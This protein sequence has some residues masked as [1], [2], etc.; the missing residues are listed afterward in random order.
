[1]KVRKGSA[2][3]FLLPILLLGI[4]APIPTYASVERNTP[5]CAKIQYWNSWNRGGASIY[6]DDTVV[7]VWN[8]EDYQAELPVYNGTIYMPMRTAEL[9]LGASVEWDEENARLAI[10]LRKTLPL[11]IPVGTAPFEKRWT[12][13]LLAQRDLEREQGVE[14][15]LRPD[16]TVEV[17]GREW[18]M[19]NAA[20][21]T[22]YPLTL[23]G[24]LYLPI[25]NVAQLCGKTILWLPDPIWGTEHLYLYDPPTQGQLDYAAEYSLK[26]QQYADQ[27]KKGFEDIEARED[28]TEETFFEAVRALKAITD[29]AVSLPYPSADTPRYEAVSVKMRWQETIENIDFCLR[30]PGEYPKL[31]PE[32][33]QNKRKSV[34][35]SG[36]FRYAQLQESIDHMKLVID[37]VIANQA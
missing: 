35:S 17:D 1:M 31:K 9:W 12:E 5:F 2:I 30:A 10:G 27:L 29:E 11:Y 19:T 16:I 23:R 36:F 25:R 32:T 18:L 20:G 7:D 24:E 6:V 3:Y 26:T 13:E 4:M 33:W 14:V 34:V 8:Q 28:L 22:V 15:E 21:E 37:A